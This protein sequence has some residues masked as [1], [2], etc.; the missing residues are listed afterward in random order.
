SSC[1]S[2]KES[3]ALYSSAWELE[4]LTGPKIAFEA[5]YPDKK[6][7][8]TFNK[9]TNK[10]EGTNSCN[11]YSADFTLNGNA[12][13][14]GEPGPTTM[15]YWGEGEQFFLNTIKKVNKYSIDDAGKL[16]LMLDDITMMRFKKAE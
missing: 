10:A 6:P 11:G 3:D 7:K 14:F 12:I 8:I 2:K 5:L 1:S 13:S 16:N 4:Y 15:M 9:D